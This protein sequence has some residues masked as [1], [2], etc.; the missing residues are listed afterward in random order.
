M[1]TITRDNLERMLHGI[2]GTTFA[3]IVVETEP[4]VKAAMKGRIKKWSKVN[5]CLGF[6]YQNS[7]NR[8]RLREELENNFVPAARR[9]GVRLEGTPLVHHKGSVYLETKV[10][11]SLDTQYYLDDTPVE[12]DDVAEY[13]PKRDSDSRQGVQ[14]EVILRDYKLESI[15]KINVK[16]MEYTIK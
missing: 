1:V 2:K 3:T 6:I 9:W 11:K 7:V 4:R 8:Q 13:L 12:Y 14:K 15:R 16:N 5:V 10:E